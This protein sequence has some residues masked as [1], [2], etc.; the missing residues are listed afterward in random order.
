M[1]ARSLKGGSLALGGGLLHFDE[2]QRTQSIAG[3]RQT[4]TGSMAESSLTTHKLDG[5]PSQKKEK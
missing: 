3:G 2:I 5:G 1:S 4:I